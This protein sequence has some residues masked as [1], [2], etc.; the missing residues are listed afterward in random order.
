MAVAGA[1]Q[2]E[3]PMSLSTWT[4]SNVD[5]TRKLVHSAV[6]GA[7]TGEEDFLHG[8]PLAEFLSVS[9]RMALRPA[10]IGAFLGIL[11]GC[12]QRRSKPGNAIIY[13]VAG[14]AF[15]F[16]AGLGWQSRRL[17]RSVVNCAWKQIGKAR[18]ERWFE[19]N[20]IDYA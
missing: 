9:L 16:G 14:C 6:E 12:A 1:W 8:E 5:Y 17:V 15:G 18:D 11:G 10:A 20:P 7:Q 2:E 13:G 19:K 4:E 3:D